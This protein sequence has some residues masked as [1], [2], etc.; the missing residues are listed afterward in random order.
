[1]IN[2]KKLNRV[3]NENIMILKTIQIKNTQKTKIVSKIKPKGY[4]E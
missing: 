3:K 4:H 2:G 1:M